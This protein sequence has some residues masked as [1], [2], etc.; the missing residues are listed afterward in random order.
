[1]TVEPA[2][3]TH[4]KDVWA[5]VALRFVLAWILLWAFFDKLLVLGCSTPPGHAWARAGRYL[6]L[7][8][9][10][11]HLELLKRHCFLSD[12]FREVL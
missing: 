3:W 11:A 2:V 4:G 5:W 10:W 6:G 1:M 7:G 9:R 8:K 12:T